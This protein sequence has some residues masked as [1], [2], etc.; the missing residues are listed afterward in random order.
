MNSLVNEKLTRGRY[1]VCDSI[2]YA[3]SNMNKTDIVGMTALNIILCFFNLIF[4]AVLTLSRNPGS[5]D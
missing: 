2:R 3:L 1:F 5:T 4:T